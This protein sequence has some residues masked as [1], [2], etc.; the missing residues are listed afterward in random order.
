MSNESARSNLLRQALRVGAAVLLGIS[1]GLEARSAPVTTPPPNIVF[2]LADDLGYADV[3]CYGRPELRTPHIDSLAR[4]G[5]RFLQAYANSAVCTA[6]RVA[7]ITGRYQY[8]LPVGLEEPLTNKPHV[9]LDPRH[10][11]L[12]SLLRQAGYRTMLVGKWHLG[13]LPNFG[14]RQSGYD[15]FYGFRSGAIDYYTH[16]NGAGREDFWEN[17]VPTRQAGY[18]T[19]LLGNRAVDVIHR[20]AASRQPFFSACISTHR[21]GLGKRRGMRRSRHGSAELRRASDILT[22]AICRRTAA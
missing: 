18:M 3:G 20:A 19:E 14:P 7:L 4:R 8:R 13:T 10:P 2:I 6:T 15:E 22:E 1:L 11:A 21:T 9:G 5:T 12:P 17:D 16:R